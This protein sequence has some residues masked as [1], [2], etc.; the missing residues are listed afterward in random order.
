MCMDRAAEHGWPAK[1]RLWLRRK[2]WG[3]FMGKYFGT[4]GVRGKANVELTPELAVSIGRAA[5][6]VLAHRKSSKQ[7]PQVL[8]GRDTR[9]SGQMLESAIAAGLMAAGADVYLV[10][11]VPTP[12]VA[13]LVR[14]Y[15]M[16]AGVMISASHNPF[17][18]NGIKLFSREGYKLSDATEAEMEEIMDGKI[19]YHC[20][21]PDALGSSYNLHGKAV[22]DY[23]EYLRGTVPGLQLDGLTIAFDCS[24]GSASMTAQKVFQ[25]FGARCLFLSDTP[26]GCN[27]N[28]DCG[29]THL[30]QLQRFVQENHCD[31]GFAFDGD[32]DRCLAVDHQGNTVD[33]DQL[34]AICALHMKQS[35]LLRGNSAVVTVMSNLGFFRF[36]QREGISTEI[37]K[38]GDRYVLEK[39]KKKGY[40]IGGEQSG[41]IIFS[42]YMPTGDGQLSALQV[43]SVM[44]QSGR[45]LEQLAQVME[46]FP[47]VLH[48]LR[49]TPE[50]R[51]RYD[52][53]P[54]VEE[55]VRRYQQSLGE[56]GR[57]L[58]RPSG[59]EPLIRVMVEGKE[60]E[61]IRAL[62]Q[63]IG[64]EILHFIE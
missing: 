34:I 9:I 31:L 43:L 13:Y 56:E 45:T 21:Q 30:K 50:Q 24:N 54:Q 44:A 36:A 40:N 53:N 15:Q 6:M 8:I 22:E 3:I 32:A 59:T 47:Q 19:P 33:G 29:S 37:T 58:V 25:G 26:D 62:A 1:Y 4:D 41:H 18:D 52:H 63:Q 23:A 10:G 20:P 14:R 64:E 57:I 11:V 46:T 17:E 42:D 61:K 38:V 28:K 27:I 7:R 48:N 51:S 2:K 5:A 39:K 12:A 49:V 55:C 60:T 16:D 35:G